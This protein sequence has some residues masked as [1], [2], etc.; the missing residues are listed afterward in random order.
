[1]KKVFSLLILICILSVLA[2]GCGSSSAP[3]ADTA[4]STDTAPSA[5]TG[6]A[7]GTAPKA[8]PF[9]DMK[10]INLIMSTTKPEKADTATTAY[11]N[12]V[13]ERTGGKVT[14]DF[15]YSGSLV[16]NPRE[17]PD[18]LQSGICDVTQLN[19]CNYPTILPLNSSAVSMPFM[20]M[21]DDTIGVYG[22]LMEMYPELEAEYR[23][24]GVKLLS[25][26]VTRPYNVHVKL[27][28]EYTGPSDF[29]GIKIAGATNADLE[30]LQKAGAVPVTVSYSDLYASLEKNVINGL[31]Q[32]AG[33]V[34]NNSLYE[35][36]N[37][38]LIFGENSG[39]FVDVIAY[40][41]R[42]ETWDSLPEAVQKV[43]IEEAAQFQ[44]ED[45]E[46]MK[47]DETSLQKVAAERGNSYI[48]LRDDQ[49][50][51]WKDLA[52]DTIEKIISENEKISPNF[53][54]MH[55]TALKLIDEAK[56]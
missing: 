31:C 17:L 3:S 21:N 55:E 23:K 18:A 42:L 38:H 33:P 44:K 37:T 36:V 35:H 7:A 40:V 54:E 12:R 14:F 29:N 16:S 53:R 8:D 48:I 15:Y 4:P 28:G 6:P 39:M 30:I 34:L 32:H 56:K 49:I 9:A 19:L 13:T 46:K 50:K 11:Y 47:A 25:Y 45:F 5:D 27:N 24:I 20:G 52:A 26:S 41:M 22:Q 43:F 1:M 51:S 2:V 10:P